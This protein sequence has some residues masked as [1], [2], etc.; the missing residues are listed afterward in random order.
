MKSDV[1][2]PVTVAENTTFH[3]TVAAVVGELPASVNDVTVGGVFSIVTD[4]LPE[5]VFPA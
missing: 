4:A 1:V 2:T 5:P 3:D